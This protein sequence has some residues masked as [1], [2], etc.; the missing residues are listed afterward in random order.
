MR[1]AVAASLLAST[2][3]FGDPL[4]QTPHGTYELDTGTAGHARNDDGTQIPSCGERGRSIYEAR[5]FAISYTKRS[6]VVDD[7]P[8]LFVADN[9]RH[10]GAVSPRSTDDVR[11]GVMFGRDRRGIASGFYSRH[12]LVDGRVRCADGVRLEGVHRR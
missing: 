10:A 12:E 3:A 5:Q 2:I 1:L 11:I 4:K 9:G 6:V 7:E 8:W